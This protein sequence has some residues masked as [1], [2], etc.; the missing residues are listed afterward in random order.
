M[1][2]K[3]LINQII[4]AYPND[5]KNC[6]FFIIRLILLTLLEGL[7]VLIWLMMEPSEPKNRFFLFYSLERWGM[8][9]FNLAFIFLALFLLLGIKK[10]KQWFYS[11]L[12]H[13]EKEK[14]AGG[15]LVFLIIL[16]FLTIGLISSFQNKFQAYYLELY[17]LLLLLVVTIVQLFIFYLVGTRQA[18]LKI[19]RTYF[20][21]NEDIQK[22]PIDSKKVVILLIG[23]SLVYLLLQF[24]AYLNVREA[25]HLGD[26]TSYL[27]GASFN[28]SDPAFFRE[29]RPWGIALAY[30][31]L[32]RSLT[33]IDFVQIFVSTFSW[34]SLAWFFSRSL[35]ESWAKMVSFLV[36]L[37]FS[38]SPVVQVWNHSALSESF[39]ISFTILILAFLIAVVQKWQKGEFIALFFLLLFWM[40]VHEVN[41][42]IGL[43]VAIAF[44]VF[45]AFRKDSRFLWVFSL[46]ISIVFIVNSQLSAA[47]ALPRWGLPL[48][49]VVTK[50]ILPN[51]EFL[52]FFVE[53]G[54]PLSPALMALSG[55]WANSGNYAVVNSPD[56]K[57]FSEWLFADGKNV[58]AKFL[59]THPLYALTA[60]LKDIKPLLA[61]N[62]EEMVPKYTPSL[63]NPINEFFY[64]VRFFWFYF[65]AS[66]I[67]V[68]FTFV[69]NYQKKN[70]VFWVVFIFWLIS[71]PYLYLTWHGDAHSVKRHIVIAN[72]QFHLGVW[73]LLLINLNEV[74]KLK[75]ES[76]EI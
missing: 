15:L 18:L 28:L 58:Y 71:I 46:F 14:Y 75:R 25:A 37:G 12:D 5:K 39:T 29:R 6:V 61:S 49:E 26:T 67:I 57:P 76:Y 33:T 60:P 53:E 62:F 19:M 40:S 45:G 10:K 13:L 30:K 9:V 51:E 48:A 54:M 68:F 66:F 32:G 56:L 22:Y 59:L 42:Y 3:S 17:P 69:K 16:F 1:P 64:P 63:P 74:S 41:L 27:E 36:I 31:I 73:L 44:L 38:L 20:P 11:H 8:I 2:F 65:W 43:L 7:G 52:G 50:R 23:I 47:Y 55:E 35:K 21:V 72:I 34:L 70:K 4:K 24:Q